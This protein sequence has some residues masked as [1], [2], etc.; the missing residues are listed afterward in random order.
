M[1]RRITKL[2]R[3]GT[4]GRGKEHACLELLDAFAPEQESG[5]PHPFTGSGAPPR[6]ASAGPVPVVS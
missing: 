1:V 2:S 3:C 5:Q 6:K 4:A